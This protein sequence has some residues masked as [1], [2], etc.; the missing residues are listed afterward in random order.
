MQ[1]LRVPKVRPWIWTTRFP[2]TSLLNGQYGLSDVCLS[3]P[4]VINRRGIARVLELGLDA[5]EIEK[6]S[7]SAAILSASIKELGL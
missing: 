7:H 6:L 4:T 1:I 5:T 3:L 2:S